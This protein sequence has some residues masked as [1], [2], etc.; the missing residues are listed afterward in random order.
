MKTR[1]SLLKGYALNTYNASLRLYAITN[2][3]HSAL[4]PLSSYY[5]IFVLYMTFVHSMI[6]V[7]H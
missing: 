7:H 6:F 5:M 1:Y 3:Y 2:S 4:S